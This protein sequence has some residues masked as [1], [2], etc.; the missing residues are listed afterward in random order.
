MRCRVKQCLTSERAR[1]EEAEDMGR[2]A[3]HSPSATQSSSVLPVDFT[4]KKKS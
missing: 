3:G 2:A 1:K 4:A